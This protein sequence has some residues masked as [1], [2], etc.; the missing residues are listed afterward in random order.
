MKKLFFVRHGET[1]T[2]VAG[3]FSGQIETSLTNAGK[4][5][6]LLTG[7]KIKSDIPRIDYIICSPLGRAYETAKI[8]A[9]EIGY[10]LKDIKRNSLFME[11]AFGVID[12]TPATKFLSDPNKYKEIDDVEGAE[13]VEQLQQR[14]A[15]ALEYVQAIDHDNIL[16]VSH[17][18]FGRAFRRVVNKLPHTDEY[19]KLLMIGNAE[20]LELVCIY[21]VCCIYENCHNGGKR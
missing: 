12:G 3:Q 4:Q 5:Q 8:I 17:G 15:K 21:L 11:R 14:A 19:N 13:T 18:A 6:A 7:Q 16:I 9:N 1:D 20:I 2:N 10:P